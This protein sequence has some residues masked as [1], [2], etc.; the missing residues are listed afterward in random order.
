MPGSSPNLDRDKHT[1]NKATDCFTPI[2]FNAAYQLGVVDYWLEMRIGSLLKN[3]FTTFAAP[4]RLN[5]RKKLREWPLA[6][7]HLKR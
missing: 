1:T 6:S 4:Y 2:L 3:G 7:C 5:F